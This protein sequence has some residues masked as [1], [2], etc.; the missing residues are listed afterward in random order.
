[1]ASVQYA[2][3]GISESITSSPLYVICEN[4]GRKYLLYGLARAQDKEFTAIVLKNT[5][6]SNEDEKKEILSSFN[7]LNIITGIE[8]AQNIKGIA[9]MEEMQ[10]EILC[11]VF[12]KYY[13]TF[14]KK[15]N[16]DNQLTYYIRSVFPT[17]RSLNGGEFL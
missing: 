13:L 7:K 17:S 2:E 10:E 6:F 5:R 4:C 8:M 12:D 15:T 3:E 14:T 9:A 11:L 1:L 16:K